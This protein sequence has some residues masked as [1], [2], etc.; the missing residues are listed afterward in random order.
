MAVDQSGSK[1]TSKAYTDNRGVQVRPLFFVSSMTNWGNIHPRSSGLNSL[2]ETIGEACSICAR[3]VSSHIHIHTQGNAYMHIME[4]VYFS[5]I[6]L[7]RSIYELADFARVTANERIYMVLRATASWLDTIVYQCRCFGHRP[8][9]NINAVK[10]NIAFLSLA[11]VYA[12]V[13][14]LL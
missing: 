13:F 5:I 2:D 6:F 4:T 12:P 9:F 3:A 14:M 11:I 7:L 10:A 1:S 8:S